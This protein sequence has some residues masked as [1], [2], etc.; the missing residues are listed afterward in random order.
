M[1]TVLKRIRRD[2]AV[3]EIF[4]WCVCLYH[5]FTAM[6]VFYLISYD[7]TPYLLRLL[8]LLAR[9]FAGS[10]CLHRRCVLS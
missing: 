4:V 7:C 2:A 3:A 8:F 10:K 1:T 9:L 5:L 6:G